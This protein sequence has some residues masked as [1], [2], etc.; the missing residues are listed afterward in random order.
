[1]FLKL[2]S[3]ST[4]HQVDTKIKQD[5]NLN[6]QT[7]CKKKVDLSGNDHIIMRVDDINFVYFCPDCEY[8]YKRRIKNEK[9]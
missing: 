7:L 2:K 3:K 4:I 1:M 9:R 8:E 5:K 6:V